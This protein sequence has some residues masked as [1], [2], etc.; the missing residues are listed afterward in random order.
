MGRVHK[1]IALPNIPESAN[2][3]VIVR[4]SRYCLSSCLGGNPRRT[5]ARHRVLSSKD[6]GAGMSSLPTGA[7]DCRGESSGT[8]SH[9]P[10]SDDD[11]LVLQ[12]RAF[13]EAAE[14]VDIDVETVEDLMQSIPADFGEEV[15][16]V[17]DR[18][19]TDD[20]IGEDT[21]GDMD[22]LAELDPSILYGEEDK[23]MSSWINEYVSTRNLPIPKLL[24]AFAINLCE[25]LQTKKPTTLLYFLKVALSRE[26]RIRDRLTQ[27]NTISDAVNLIRS[28][29]RI[30]ILTGAG[31]SVS[32]GIPDFRS[33]DG[34]YASLKDRGQY[35]LDDP[36]Q[37]FDINY[38]RENPA[39]PNYEHDS[40]IY[41]SN[42]TPSPCHRFIKL[43]EDKDQLLRNYTQNIDT[44]ETLAGVQHVLQCHGS[45]AT[46]SCLLC[47]RRVPG[48][49]IEAD[50]LNQKVALCTVCN[51]SVPTPKKK[52]GKKKAKGQ[53]DSDD[54]D[55]SDGAVYPPGI[56]KPDITFFG[57][58]LTDDFD[59]SLA[60]D[61]DRV[62]LL[63][64][65]GT[66]L[67]V[68]PVADIV[69]RAD[70]LDSPSPA[71]STSAADLCIPFFKI[72]INKTPIRHIN[73]DIVL[74]GNADG[75][76]QYLCDALS[77]KLPAPPA[78]IIPPSVSTTSP[79]SA[80]G[81]T[82]SA[83]DDK[84]QGS[85]PSDVRSPTQVGDS[86]VWLFDGAE[87]GRWLKELKQHLA[88]ETPSL[89][90][91]NVNSEASTRLPSPMPTPGSEE[92]S[93][94]KRENLDVSQEE[95]AAKK[96]RS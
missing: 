91:L 46:A 39:A 58:K 49:E 83:N 55:E 5:C 30:I 74:L 53:W 72:L 82:K 90:P 94:K 31:I 75:I 78:P 16:P 28:S 70:T 36:Q 4:T 35:D 79:R 34:L 59:N 40:Q 24:R 29:R 47:R 42:F 41:P 15:D 37:M 10:P 60:E 80:Q 26:L 86:H 85:G 71:L 57:E 50:I 1:D 38:F 21:S 89:T 84:L 18:E 52:R 22:H 48:S 65:I 96:A 12:V 17:G 19:P 54:E 3:L 33:R 68:S 20:D 56:M 87:G 76:V 62:D 69:Y 67:K 63:L 43:V 95:R 51:L 45:F 88:V 14:D 32:C 73:P 61:R 11:V 9:Q 13:L 93:F 23:G 92:A 6:S 66:S 25:V 7:Q 81:Q 2:R 77:W 64:I 27:Y 8:A 44:L